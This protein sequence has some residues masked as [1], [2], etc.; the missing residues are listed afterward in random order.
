MLAL[1]HRAHLQFTVVFR[2]LV[3]EGFLNSLCDLGV[4]KVKK[5]KTKCT[6]LLDTVSCVKFSYSLETYR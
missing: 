2:D 4:K 6:V 1:V 3:V 5:N